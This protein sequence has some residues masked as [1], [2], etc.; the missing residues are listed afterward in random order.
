MTVDPATA[1]HR[2]EYQG[3]TYC[4]CCNGCRTKF[5]ADPQKYLAPKADAPKPASTAATTC[6]RSRERDSLTP[7]TN[8][9]NNPSRIALFSLSAARSRT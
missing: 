5:E 8:V 6:D 2:S 3:R 4:F 9:L 7:A 1:K